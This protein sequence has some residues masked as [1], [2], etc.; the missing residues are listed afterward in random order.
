MTFDEVKAAL[1]RQAMREV[2]GL[3]FRH[4]GSGKVREIYDLGETLLLIA[5]DRLSAFD[6]V[7]PDGIPGK[8]ILLTQASL[9]WFR[10]TEGLIPNHLVED[11][12]DVLRETLKDFPQLVPYSMLV[13]KLKPVKLEAVV[14]GYLAGGGWK[15]YKQTGKLFGIDLPVGLEDSSKLPE[16]LFTPTTKADEGHDMPI[17]EPG[18]KA[19]IGVAAYDRIKAV[20]LEIF[21]MGTEKAAASGLILADTKFEFG[22]DAEGTLY[23]IDE[24]L[25]PDSSRYWP[26]ED[27]HPG[28]PQTAFDKQYVRD[29][30]ETLD[31]GKTYP[32][33]S[34]PDEVIAKTQERYLTALEKLWLSLR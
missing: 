3:P 7:L 23:L 26:R 4:L 6:V 17:D 32:G 30:L 34:L 21:R 25:T 5:T 1:P 24:V 14:R 2:S 16:P 9:W 20:S 18:A 10:Q 19:L 12:D 29:Y 11:H 15:D 22:T 33:P 13:K 28:G 31:W 8:G 27:Y